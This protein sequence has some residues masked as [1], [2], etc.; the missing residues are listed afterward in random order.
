MLGKKNYSITVNDEDGL[1]IEYLDHSDSI[2][3]AYLTEL[4]KSEDKNSLDQIV[5]SLVM[6]INMSLN[7]IFSVDLR[8]DKNVTKHKFVA[9]PTV[10]EYYK[11]DGRLSAFID[12]MVI[13][14]NQ[15]VLSVCRK[16]GFLDTF[17][18]IR[19]LDLDSLED[20]IEAVLDKYLESVKSLGYENEEKLDGFYGTVKDHLTN[21][22]SLGSGNE[23]QQH[24]LLLMV[25]V[26][27]YML[28]YQSEDLNKI[29]DVTEE[30]TQIVKIILLESYVMVFESMLK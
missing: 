8:D 29:Y 20:V 22:L 19:Y 10:K 14:F 16:D 13:Q 24:N 15:L 3:N 17:P 26:L 11:E 30:E 9:Y 21:V 18:E 12:F 23:V 4:L 27:T 6:P 7:S 25:L 5:H 28:F 1:Y 2:W